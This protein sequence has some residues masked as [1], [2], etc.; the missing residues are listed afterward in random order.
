MWMFGQ[1]SASAPETSHQEPD[2]GYLA[3]ASDLMI[4]LLFIFIILVVVLAL[5]QTRQQQQLEEQREAL[6]NAGDPRGR[7]TSSIGVQVKKVL[8][9]VRIDPA[10]GVISLPEEVLFDLASAE[11]KPSGRQ[12]LRGAI[13]ELARV[14]PCYVANQHADKPCDENPARHEIETIFIEGHT[15]NLPL[16]RLNYDNTNLSLDRARAVF[17]ALVRDGPLDAYRNKSGQPLF[18]LSAYGETRPLPDISP[19]D[20]RNRRVDLRVVLSYRPISELL[21]GLAVPSPAR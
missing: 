21:P 6:I 16:R 18:S 12:A 2:S 9:T 20:A 7:V 13:A 11:L 15:D 3:S 5:E 19:S 10:S 17:A 1:P 8:P 4:G 14:L